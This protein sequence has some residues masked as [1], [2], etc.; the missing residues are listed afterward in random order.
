MMTTGYWK[1]QKLNQLLVEEE[2]WYQWAK[3]KY[4]NITL[5]EIVR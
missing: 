1:L 2:F 5:K 3:V 4:I